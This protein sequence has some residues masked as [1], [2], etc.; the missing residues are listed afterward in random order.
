VWVAELDTGSMEN[1]ASGLY[2]TVQFGET[3]ERLRVPFVVRVFADTRVHHMR[4]NAPGRRVRI[5]N[6]YY[7][8]YI[9]YIIN[10]GS[11]EWTVFIPNSKVLID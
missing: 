1:I 9:I 4:R 10:Y 7:I 8:I 11:S 3:V 2:A 6:V 5:F